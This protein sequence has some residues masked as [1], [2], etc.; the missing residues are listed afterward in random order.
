V[1][2]SDRVLQGFRLPFDFAPGAAG[3]VAVLEDLT[4]RVV[5][6]RDRGG[7]VA[8]PGI[9]NPRV[10]AADKGGLLLVL[11]AE[12]GAAPSLVGFRN[13]REETRARVR[14]E[15]TPA[16]PVGMDAREGIIWVA[17]RSPP[18]LL[19]YAYDGASLGWV[20]LAQW[21]RSPFAVA[22]GPD[23]EAFVT[24]PLG[25]AILAFSPTGAYL[26]PLDLAGTGVT[27]PTGVAVDAEGRVWASDGVTGRVVCFGPSGDRSAVR[28]GGE[29]LR[30]E[31]P[32]RIS[33]EKGALWV[34]EGKQGRARRFGSAGK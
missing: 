18:R 33:W 20:D 5:F 21:A 34:L 2:A 8:L 17:D 4:R 22:L 3:G 24:D 30:F 31:D 26:G 27:R 6:V 10:L 23:G 19:L 14:G 11:D 7:E 9:K 25:P 29:T 13:G 12:P 28:C 16:D 32:L 1:S 15:D